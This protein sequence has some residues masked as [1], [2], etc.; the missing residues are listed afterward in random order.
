L[1][2][3]EQHGQNEEA[4][5]A[6][7]HLEESGSY[8]TYPAPMVARRKSTGADVAANESD[9]TERNVGPEGTLRTAQ[10]HVS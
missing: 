8:R 2:T 4:A 6:A 10:A 7:G 9:A 1:K 5:S 3:A